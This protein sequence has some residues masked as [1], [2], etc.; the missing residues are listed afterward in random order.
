MTIIS[1]QCIDS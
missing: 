1:S